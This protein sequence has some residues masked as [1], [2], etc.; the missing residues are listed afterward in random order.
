MSIYNPRVRYDIVL[1]DGG[2]YD[3]TS[4]VAGWMDNRQWFV[5]TVLH[6]YPVGTV[7]HNLRQ[8]TRSGKEFR[9]QPALLAAPAPKPHAFHV[10]KSRALRSMYQPKAAAGV[11][12]DEAD[13]IPGTRAAAGGQRLGYVPDRILTASYVPGDD[14]EDPFDHYPGV[15]AY[16]PPAP[17]PNVPIPPPTVPVPDPTTPQRDISEI[18]AGGASPIVTNDNPDLRP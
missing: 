15:R 11:G 9:N 10:S 5:D 16:R 18:D 2:R 7:V 12:D 6:G 8:V 17:N 1:P 14:D 13:V 3:Q 4:D